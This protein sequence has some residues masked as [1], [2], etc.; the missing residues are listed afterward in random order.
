[1][2]IYKYSKKITVVEEN[3]QELS[4]YHEY[5]KTGTLNSEEPVKKIVRFLEEKKINPI[6]LES[7]P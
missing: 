6:F 5:S 2:V 1:M 3:N 4:A 7:R